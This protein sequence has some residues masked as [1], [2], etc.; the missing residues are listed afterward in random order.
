MERYKITSVSQ[1]KNNLVKLTLHGKNKSAKSIIYITLTGNESCF[2]IGSEFKI[3]TSRDSYALLMAYSY[4][5]D[6][7]PHIDILHTPPQ[8]EKNAKYFFNQI[9]KLR[10]KS[11]DSIILKFEIAR[12]LWAIG[13]IPKLSYISNFYQLTRE[14]R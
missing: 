1:K 6:N 11:L 7:L 14:P 13:A 4:K 9:P 12:A 3:Y 8:E 10:D 5:L 2:K